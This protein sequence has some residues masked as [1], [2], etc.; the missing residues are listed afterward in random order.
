M[1]DIKDK[2][3]DERIAV[4]ENLLKECRI[5]V[6]A[7][8]KIAKKNNTVDDSPVDYSLSTKFLEEIDE[9]LDK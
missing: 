1:N 4:L 6:K 3:K 8:I 2:E 9:V 5:Y 7:V